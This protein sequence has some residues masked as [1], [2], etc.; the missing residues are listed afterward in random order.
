MQYKVDPDDALAL[1]S[2]AGLYALTG[3]VAA[4]LGLDLLL[5]MFGLDA[6]RSPLGVSLALAAAIIGGARI[7]YGAIASLL[8][9]SAGA[10]LALAIAMVAAIALGEY[11]VAAEFVLIAMIGESLEALTF[12]R[13]HREI[14]CILELRPERVR[15]RRGGQEIE[16]PSAEVLV[17]DTVVVRPGERIAVDGRV[18]SGRSSVDQSTLTGESLPVD[19]GV[20]DA[21]YAGTLNQFGALEIATER[22]GSQTTLGQV[23][24]MVA[25][26]Q[27]RKARVERIADRMARAFLPMVLTAAAVTFAATNIAGLRALFVGGPLPRWDWMPTLAVLVVTCPCALI[28]ATPAAM[29]AALAWTAKRGVLVKGGYALERLATVR[30]LAFDKTGTLTT[31]Q[32]KVADIVPLKGAAENDLLALAAAAEQSSEHV[33]GAALVA[34]AKERNLTLAAIDEFTALPGAGVSARS[35]AADLLVGNARLMRERG[36]E[37]DDKTQAA[38]ER[39]EAAGQTALLIARDSAVQG[40]VGVSDTVRPEAADVIRQLRAV[41]IEE[42]AMLTGDRPATAAYVARSLGIDTWQA[43][44][45]PA[46]KA[47]WLT[48]WKRRHQGDDSSSAVVGMVGD[49]VNDAPAL[50]SADAGLALGGIGSHLAAE[51]GDMVL[52]GAPLTPLPGLI[53][54][55]RETVRVI[56]QNIILFAFFANILGIVL[57]AW[58]MPNWSEAWHR[59]APIAAAVFHQVGSVLVLLNAMRLLWFERWQTSW[60]GLT[61]NA[62]AQWIDRFAE[63]FGFVRDGWRWSWQHRRSVGLGAVA[64]ATVAYFATG[65]VAVAPDEIAVVQR[66]GRLLNR[67]LYPGLHV[68]LPWPWDR[69]TR[70]RAERVFTV[71]VGMR[72]RVVPA[73]VDPDDVEAAEALAREKAASPTAIEWNSPHERSTFDRLES[74]SIVLT[75]DHSLVELGATVQCRVDEPAQWL[76]TVRDPQETLRTLAESTIRE[77]LATHPVIAEGNDKAQ[78]A[79]EILTAGRAEIEREIAERLQQRI[80]DLELGVVVLDGGVC[81]QDVHP[82]LDVV[83]AFRDVS[84]AFKE[85]GRM[86]NEA[87]ADYR[88]KVILA[89]G[90]NAWEQLRATGAEMNEALWS[91]MRDKLDGEAAAELHSAEAFAETRANVAEG[92]ASQFRQVQQAEAV[93]PQLT[94]WRMYV[95]AVS[96]ALAGKRKMV[97]D[98][99]GGGRRQLLLGAPQSMNESLRAL[100]NAA[101]TPTVDPEE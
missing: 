28:L 10:D 100:L 63:Q 65:L 50:A 39:I 91:E 52:I 19:K 86:L 2:F 31:G 88:K 101:Q 70:H 43:E 98:S 14:Q 72:S 17:G 68:C 76:F 13:T 26:A 99:A 69:V 84:S 46:E 34:A 24:Q 64:A 74:E 71:E 47:E 51:A 80:E 85:K 5:W 57:T 36:I 1:P 92:E 35:N 23:I 54:L 81:L 49:G 40:I 7:V 21:V 12:S 11:W 3:L 33:I 48:Q 38:L 22:V 94:R 25:D 55:S 97:F 37:L 6:M 79:R 41:G 9:G 20:D 61:E 59:R 53:Q 16:V 29:M 45:R 66:C 60:F 83:P 95:D 30:Y 42:V 27:A 75:G 4:L 77:V 82:P 89:A 58:I 32:L 87:D 18:S 93:A 96:S 8:E 44:L 56:R 67:T 62:I 15:V 78:H 73:M 90:K